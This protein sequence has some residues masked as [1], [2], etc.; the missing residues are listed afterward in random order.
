MKLTKL[1]MCAL[2][3]LGLVA[4]SES[5]SNNEATQKGYISFVLSTT[6]LVENVTRAQIT[7]GEA[8]GDFN[9]PAD[10]DFKI[11]IID[12]ENETVWSGKLSEWS[13]T[14]PLTAGNYTV[15]A[16]YDEGRVGFNSPVFSGSA[17]VAVTGG[18]TAKVEIPVT[19]QNAIV[20][21]QYTDTFKN[22]YSFEKFTVTS[23][24]TAIDFTANETRGAF[25]EA[26]SFTIQGELTSQAQDA[27]GGSPTKTFSKEYKA[28]AAKCY[29]IT[30]DASNIGG[31][32]GIQITFGDQPT[33]TVELGDTELNE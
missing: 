33:E 15:K 23:L 30:F 1:T 26:S 17:P 28:S 14:T 6:D 21:L 8:I 22:Y 27:N 10:G 9:A 25:I 11:E 7:I 18:E 31:V 19:L 2:A 13:S 12:D 3:L 16:S 20:R 24:G 32:N 4:C 5:D 29:T